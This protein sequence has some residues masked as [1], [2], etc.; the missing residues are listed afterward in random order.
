MVS[1]IGKIF[2]GEYAIDYINECEEFTIL[3]IGANIGGFA[4]WASYVWDNANVICYEPI[5]A[6]FELLVQNVSDFE[7]ISYYNKAVGASSQKRIMYHGKNNSGECSFYP[8]LDQLT[9]GELVSVISGS[10][11]PEAEI[12]KIDTE[13]AEIEILQSINFQPHVY[14]IEYHS[15]E[16]KKFIDSYLVNYKLVEHKQTEIHFGIVIYVL[17]D[18]FLNS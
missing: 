3:D 5:K 18:F 13:G 2:D 14:M 9:S 8:G 7:N 10:E 4:I 16:N 1:H 11:L 6:N 15:E 12:V 17:K